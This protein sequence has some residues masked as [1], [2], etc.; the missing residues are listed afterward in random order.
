MTFI[1]FLHGNMLWYSLEAPL[2]GA[3]NEYLQHTFSGEINKIL[4]GY[5]L[6]SRVKQSLHIVIMILQIHKAHWSGNL[7]IFRPFSEPL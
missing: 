4:C 2:R 7:K 5:A 3:S 6:F 1:L